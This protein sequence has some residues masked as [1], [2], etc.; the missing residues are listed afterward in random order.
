MK[1]LLVFFLVIVLCLS[2]LPGC[3]TTS[4]S[5]NNNDTEATQN[6]APD[7][8]DASSTE[9]PTEAPAETDEPDQTEAT[10]TAY[11]VT[12]K[13]CIVYKNSIGT[14]WAHVVIQVEN[15]GSDALYLGTASVDI[16]D[17]KEH[18]VDTLS[19]VSGYPQVL[20]P[21]E[22]AL[23]VEDT[24]LDED[25][26]ETELNVIPHLDIRKATIDCVRFET[27]EEE[28]YNADY[29]GIKM[30]GRVKNTS[31]DTQNMIYI[32]ANLYDAEHHG[33]GQLMTIITSDL[34]PDEKIGFD[35]SCLSMPD[36]IK[37][38]NVASFEVFAFPTQYQFN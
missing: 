12:Y 17:S 27:L 5:S 1:R 4:T 11:E 24:T 32:V 9:V 30:K 21:G 25:P 18:L 20:N 36:T 6:N 33:I 22:T 28:L 13:N 7:K 35:L 16:E 31:S 15:T 8:T 29:V 37:L 23:L 14:V 38:E 34:A 3:M 26:G 19:L 2:I 10:G